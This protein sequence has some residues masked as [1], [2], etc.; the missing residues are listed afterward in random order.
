MRLQPFEKTELRIERVDLHGADLGAV[1]AVV[2]DVFGLARDDVLVI[3][4]RDDRLALDVHR[5]TLDPYLVVGAEAA[6]LTGLSQVP[7]LTVGADTTISAEGMLGWIAGDPV[8]GRA[9]L[10]RAQR[11]VSEIE[12][13]IA[14]RAVVFSTGPEVASGRIRDTNTPFLADVLTLA[15]YTVTS[16]PTLADDADH[17]AAA[18]AEAV[19]D[20]GFG[21]VVTTGGVGAEAKDTTVEALLR[22]DPTAATPYLCTF[23]V[24]H[25]RHHKAGVRIGVSRRPGAVVVALPGPH[26]E[27]RLGADALVSGLAA[28]LP[29]AALAEHIARPLRARL[30]AKAGR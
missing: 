14:A 22:L 5:A 13:T 6:L 21:L 11:M 12:C 29:A 8:E 30:R 18:L 3:D 2:A 27:V 17:I 19:E 26:D 28:D 1:A 7:G 15:G 23:Q 24:G 4:A 16:G 10:D 20:R 25:G 9:V